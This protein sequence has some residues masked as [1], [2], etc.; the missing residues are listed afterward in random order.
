MRPWDL[1]TPGSTA[2]QVQGQLCTAIGKITNPTT[3]PCNVTSPSHLHK[4]T[5]AP[6]R[7]PKGKANNAEYSL[8]AVTNAKTLTVGQY[9]IH[10]LS[11]STVFTRRCC[12]VESMARRGHAPLSGSSVWWTSPQTVAQ[13]SE[14]CFSHNPTLLGQGSASFSRKGPQRVI[15][16]L[17]S[18]GHTI[19]VAKIQACCVPQKQPQTVCIKGHN[20]VST[21]FY[22][23]KL[24][25]GD[26]P[27]AHRPHSANPF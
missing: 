3:E 4:S 6:A 11:P 14:G 9:H 20:C 21:K 10:T 12:A 27:G 15:N 25:A 13:L 2:L 1:G 22:S 5:M 7:G 23:Q 17:E 24:A 26:L 18:V 8:C 19:S 16:V